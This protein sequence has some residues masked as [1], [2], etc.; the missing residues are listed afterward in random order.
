MQES[1]ICS[2]C[3]I[4]GVSGGSVLL[5]ASPSCGWVSDSWKMVLVSW[6]GSILAHVHGAGGPSSPH[7]VS[8]TPSQPRGGF[9][10]G[11]FWGFLKPSQAF[12]LC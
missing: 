6:K 11:L 4:S 10:E 8:L 12:F 5:A 3:L 2:E 1:V 7:E 9:S